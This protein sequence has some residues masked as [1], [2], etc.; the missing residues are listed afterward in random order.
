MFGSINQDSYK[1]KKIFIESTIPAELIPLVELSSN[2]WW[3]WNN[4]AIALFKHIAGPTWEKADY[5]PIE[6]LANLNQEKALQLKNDPDFMNTLHEVHTSFKNYMNT[7]RD[8]DRPSI[9]YFCMEFGMHISVRLYSGGLGILAGD[10]LKEASDSNVRMIGMGLLYRYGY[11]QQSISLHGEQINQY[12]PQKFT[13][14]PMRPVRGKSD[15]WLKISINLKGRTVWAKIWEL[16]VGRVSLFLL[17]TD[18]DENSWEDR[19]L[20]HQLYG[21]DNEH[22]LKQEILL[23]I[24][25]IRALEVMGIEKEVYHCNEGHATFLGL[26][27]I[28]HLVQHKGLTFKEAQEVVRASLL[29]TT[30]TPVPAGHDYFPES[31]LKV[32]L[33]Q[34]IAELGISWSEFIGLGRIHPNDSNELFSM[35]HLAIR[36][37]QEVNGVSAL[38]GKVSRDMFNVLYLGYH[39]EELHIGH[40]TNGVHYP[41]WISNSLHQLFMEAFGSDFIKDQS[42]KKHWSKIF[43]VDNGRLWEIRKALKNKLVEKIKSQL[44]EDLTRRGE[45]PKFIFEQMNAINP[46]ALFIGFA[47][48]FATYKRAN[49]LFSNLQRLSTLVNRAN[50]PIVFVYSGKAHPADRGGQELIKQIV[51]ISKRPE[52]LGKV[53]FLENYNMEIASL[54][55]QGVDIW[56]NTPTRPKEAS[57]TSG[58]KA[59][60]NG[61]VNFSVLDGWWAEGYRPDAG[62]SLPLENTYSDE[63]LQNELDAETIYNR[64]DFE[65]APLYFDRNEKGIPEKWLFYVKNTIAEVAPQFTMKRM[66]D[67]Y[68][69]QYYI[70]MA[71]RSQ[72]VNDNEYQQAKDIVKWKDW[73]TK[74]W[75]GIRLESTNI[76]DTFNFSLEAGTP[77]EAEITLFLNGIVPAEVGLE[78]VFFK[79]KD[80]THL[81]LKFSKELDLVSFEEKTATYKCSFLPSIIGVYE[82]G[83][84]IFPKHQWM[85]HRQ[86]LDLVSWL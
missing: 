9:A 68:Y 86:D 76:Y 44:Q 46:N 23:G 75:P 10:Y 13:N 74:Q 36:L 17:D 43:D 51:N 60:L 52:F 57:G 20:T 72:S 15:E 40:V 83:F 16:G 39:P 82:Y 78:V 85:P 4:K 24:G 49:L 45:N 64:L 54:L 62:W 71:A 38:H 67:D 27:R 26:E 61:V 30:H 5:N 79:R 29:F 14:L 80:E 56:L 21:G 48:R 1:L 50:Y 84:R 47:R 12:P 11:F 7:P 19:S 73:M 42:N 70:K 69:N 8:L 37:S 31:L 66:L 63:S 33:S 2:L 35:S 25:G 53:I 34:Y 18:I 32:Y 59:A 81:D 6:V 22:R 3:S 77:F 28:K 65:I 41:T 55:V 58:M